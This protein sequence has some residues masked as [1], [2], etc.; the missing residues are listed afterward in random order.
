MYKEKKKYS[1]INGRKASLDDVDRTLALV[2]Q[3]NDSR[4]VPAAAVAVGN[5]NAFAVVVVAVERYFVDGT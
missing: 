3:Q 1:I 4:A 5:A 2:R